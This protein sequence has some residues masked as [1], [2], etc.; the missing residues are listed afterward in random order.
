MTTIAE[1]H[2]EI[3]DKTPQEIARDT[4]KYAFTEFITFK[5]RQGVQLED[6]STTEGRIWANT[7]KTY[8]EQ[9]DVGTVWWGRTVEERDTVILVVGKPDLPLGKRK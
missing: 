9:D 6:D 3:Y 1:L 4:P 5:F 2:A 7:V 8:L